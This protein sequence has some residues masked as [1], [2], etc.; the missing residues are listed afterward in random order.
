MTCSREFPKSEEKKPRAQARGN[1]Y[2]YNLFFCFLFPLDFAEEESA[3][4]T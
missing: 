4:A 3:L 1:P 2:V